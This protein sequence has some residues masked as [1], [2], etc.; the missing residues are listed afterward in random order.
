MI[1]RLI[2]GLGAVFTVVP[3]TWA[4]VQHNAFSQRRQ[5]AISAL[6]IPPDAVDVRFEYEEACFG[7]CNTTSATFRIVT[8]RDPTSEFR[9]QAA[10]LGIARYPV[11]ENCYSQPGDWGRSI[12]YSPDEHV[13]TIRFY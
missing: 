4:L 1:I 8:E 13:Y 3:I 9:S 7:F 5:V 10:K 2:Y 12:S 6:P 11:N